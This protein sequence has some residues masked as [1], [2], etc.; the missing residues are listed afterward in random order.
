MYLG[1]VQPL[2]PEQGDAEV[3]LSSDTLQVQY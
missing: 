1:K 2:T 3:W